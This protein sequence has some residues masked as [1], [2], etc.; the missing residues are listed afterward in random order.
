VSQKTPGLSEEVIIELEFSL[1]DFKIK[2][3]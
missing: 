1:D 2:L 3:D